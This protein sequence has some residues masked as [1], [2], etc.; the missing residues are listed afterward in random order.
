LIITP[1]SLRKQWYQEL[2]DKF[3]LESM[4]IERKTFDYHL[5]KGKTNPFEQK[6]IVITNLVVRLKTRTFIG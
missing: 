4:I 6:K 2:L 5:E 3:Y 1:S